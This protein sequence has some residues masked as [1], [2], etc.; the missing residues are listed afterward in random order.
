MLDF[1]TRNENGIRNINKGPN[2]II[3]QG[4]LFMVLMPVVDHRLFFIITRHCVL[5]GDIGK[6]HPARAEKR[7]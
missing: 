3:D 7:T 2:G 1:Q 4:N 6:P 5:V